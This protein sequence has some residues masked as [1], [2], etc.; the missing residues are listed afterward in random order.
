MKGKKG[1]IKQRR[2]INGGSEDNIKNKKRKISEK[3]MEQK[4]EKRGKGGKIN[5]GKRKK[6]KSKGGSG[7]KSEG[8][9][10]RVKKGKGQETKER[11][12][13][14]LIRKRNGREGSGKNEGRI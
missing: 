7:T 10:R 3:C 8:R 4:V 14:E 12:E 13:E 1:R 11:Q 9:N 5:V 6:K 2:E